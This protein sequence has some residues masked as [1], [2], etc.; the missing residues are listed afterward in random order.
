MLSGPMW[1]GPSS[2][3]QVV[4]GMQSVI[5]DVAGNAESKIH[6]QEV[7]SLVL[8]VG[9]LCSNVCFL[10]SFL[11]LTL[12]HSPLW[13]WFL[14]T[15]RIIQSLQSL[16]IACRS[17]VIQQSA[18]TQAVLLKPRNNPLIHFFLFPGDCGPKR[19]RMIFKWLNTNLDC[20]V[21]YFTWA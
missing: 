17:P 21:T 13:C 9:C 10:V 1:S 15:P 19:R 6:T 4:P 18:G 8:R 2:A 7:F 12:T 16:L 5:P 11:C 20:P 3:G 14:C